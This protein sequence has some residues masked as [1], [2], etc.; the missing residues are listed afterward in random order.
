MRRVN[1]TIYV[2]SD[3]YYIHC[4]ND[5]LV[6]RKEENELVRIPVVSIEQLVIFGNTTISSFLVGFCA[7]HNILLTYVSS[8]GM[9]YGTFHGA[10]SG[11]VLLR[12]KQ[13]SIKGQPKE[14]DI[15]RNIVLGKAINSRH[16]LIRA[17]K[18]AS[19]DRAMNLKQA[20]E[21]IKGNIAKLE[22][23]NNIDGLRGLEGII[24]E[25]YFS[26]FDNMLKT[27]DSDMRFDKR[28]K[29]PPENYCN[30]ALSLLYTLLTSNC[31]S[32]LNSV[33]LDSEFGYLHSLRPGRHSLACDLIEELMTCIVDRFVIT[34]INRKQITGKDFEK[35]ESGIKFK[36]NKISEFLNK[37]EEY[38]S[39][40]IVHPLYKTKVQ[41]KTI[42]Y[43]QAQLLAQCVRGDIVEYPPI[44]WR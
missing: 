18:N 32:A 34:M 25:I 20:A 5:S 13:Y 31:E 2:T 43:I 41:I 4:E 6:F 36:D 24:A 44:E 42:P 7:K 10:I 19:E 30:S 27:S 23:T 39:E 15:A 22:K 38:K 8:H 12:Q 1:K 33:G 28:S 9:Y 14:V 40:E 17:I 37:W 29:R 21:K 35:D 16:T 11:N 3:G 26:Q